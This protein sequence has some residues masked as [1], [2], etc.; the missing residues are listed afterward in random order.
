MTNMSNNSRNSWSTEVYTFEPKIL[1][2]SIAYAL[3]YGAGFPLIF[4]PAATAQTLDLNLKPA[5]NARNKKNLNE[6][7][8]RIRK[9]VVNQQ[10]GDLDWDALQNEQ[11]KLIEQGRQVIKPW[12]PELQIGLN[13]WYMDSWESHSNPKKP[14]VNVHFPPTFGGDI[15][16]GGTP[17]VTPPPS[18]IGRM[19]VR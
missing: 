19:I 4:S 10:T 7:S 5:L 16:I 6:F 18:P 9:V 1:S 13:Y 11:Y 15:P 17:S 3:V 14:Y 12:E 8:D 2:K